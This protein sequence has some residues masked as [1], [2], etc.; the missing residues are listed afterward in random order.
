MH[1]NSLANERELMIFTHGF[2]LADII[3][4]DAFR[5]FLALCDREFVTEKSFLDHLQYKFK[6]LDIDE[7]GEIERWEIQKLFTDMG[8]PMAE[9]VLDELIC[10]CRQQ[11]LSGGN[12]EWMSS[13]IN[14]IPSDNE[15][16]NWA[17]LHRLI[18]RFAVQQNNNGSIP[19]SN[20]LNRLDDSGTDRDGGGTGLKKLLGAAFS[21]VKKTTKAE[22][23][24]LFSFKVICY[25]TKRLLVNFTF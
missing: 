1:D 23:A 4:D 2:L 14:G 7:T 10:K 11:T 12:A 20:S 5:V 9:S 22:Y 17:I 19:S 8:I 16:V 24:A 6:E 15:N 18:T 3:I 21:K 13:N 25:Q